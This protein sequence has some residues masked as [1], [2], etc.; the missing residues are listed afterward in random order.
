MAEEAK[1]PEV[2]SRTRA[3]AK[4]Q[5]HEQREKERKEK[6]DQLKAEYAQIKDSLALED[7]LAKAKQFAGWHLKLAKD[8]VGSKVVGSNDSG[9]PVTEEYYLT[10]EQRI[11]ELDQAKGQEQLIAYIEAKLI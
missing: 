8:G 7:I 9:Q 2:D 1:K 3:Q 11:S 4:K 10:Q 5:L 6:L